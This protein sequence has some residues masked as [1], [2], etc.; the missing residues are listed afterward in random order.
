MLDQYG[1]KF[2]EKIT[3]PIG[4]TLY[5]CG[6][7]ADLLTVLGLFVAI[8]TGFAVATGHHVLAGAGV[9]VAGIP[10]LLDGS[11]ARASGKVNSRGQFLDSLCDRISDAALFTGAVWFYAN[12]ENSQAFMAALSAV[13]L[14][15]SLLISYARALA[16]AIGFQ[17]KGGIME[18]A[19]RLIV[20]GASVTF[21]YLWLGIW[22][23]ALLGSVTLIQRHIKVWKLATQANGLASKLADLQAKFDMR[24][25]NLS[26]KR[27][28]SKAKRQTLRKR[29]QH[30]KL[31]DS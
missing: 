29:N 21:G 30:N 19:E 28:E 11:I 27:A 9:L 2:S 18:R 5:K 26:N 8:A 31:E 1:R 3:S 6:I 4:I 24:V 25:E 22:I 14:T 15:V 20:F 13:A 10:D 16:A 7:S 17:I 23:I 12:S